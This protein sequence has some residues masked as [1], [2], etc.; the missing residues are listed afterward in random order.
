LCEI[1]LLSP[2]GSYEATVTLRHLHRL[3]NA[4]YAEAKKSYG[5]GAALFA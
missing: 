2:R 3:G 4:N 1:A 5:T